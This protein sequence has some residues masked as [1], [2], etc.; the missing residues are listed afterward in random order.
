VTDDRDSRNARCPVECVQL[1]CGPSAISMRESYM[2]RCTH[3][4]S[5]VSSTLRREDA[6][7]L[8][9]NSTSSIVQWLGFTYRQYV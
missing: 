8:M 9:T 6:K 3:V 7:R 2:H 4:A 5:G 1:S